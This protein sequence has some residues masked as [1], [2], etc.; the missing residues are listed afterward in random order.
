MHVLPLRRLTAGTLVF[1]FPLTAL[2]ATRT[3]DA[4]GSDNNWSTAANWSDDTV[5]TAVDIA[6][7][8]GT[9]KKNATIDAAFGGTVAELRLGSSNTG[10]TSS[11]WTWG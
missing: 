8:D 11:S 1:L 5:P 2:A 9:G 4:G 7:F 10:T 6:L 3:W